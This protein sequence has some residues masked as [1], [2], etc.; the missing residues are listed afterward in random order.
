VI[1]RRADCRS[2]EDDWHRQSESSEDG[3]FGSKA[4]MSRDA[5]VRFG[6]ISNIPW[7]R[8]AAPKSPLGQKL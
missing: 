3:D 2:F 4:E 8:T 1:I 6:A 5:T 7:L